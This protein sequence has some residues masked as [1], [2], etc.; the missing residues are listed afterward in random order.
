MDASDLASSSARAVRSWSVAQSIRHGHVSARLRHR[1]IALSTMSSAQKAALAAGYG[2]LFVLALLTAFHSNVA[3]T[4]MFRTA[5]GLYIPLSVLL[6]AVPIIVLVLSFATSAAMLANP[7]ARWGCVL[8]VVFAFYDLTLYATPY[9]LSEPDLAKRA[10]MAAMRRQAEL[11]LAAPALLLVLIAAFR[12]WLPRWVTPVGCLLV[13]SLAA[14]L[15]WQLDQLPG[16]E[17]AAW[18]VIDY[19]MLG[20]IYLIPALLVVGADIAEWAEIFGEVTAEGLPPMRLSREWA[21]AFVI[22]A[23]NLSIVG[24]WVAKSG[25]AWQMAGDPHASVASAGQFA[26]AFTILT[27]G[28]ATILALLLRFPSRVDHTGHFGYVTILAI[29]YLTLGTSM[30][31]SGYLTEDAPPPTQVFRLKEATFSIE[32]ARGWKPHTTLDEPDLAVVD[33]FAPEESFGIVKVIASRS[34]L[35][36]QI[37][38]V[39]DLIGSAADT[40]PSTPLQLTSIPPDDDGWR[41]FETTLTR[42]EH[43]HRSV[44]GIAMDPVTPELA[45]AIGLSEARGVEVTGVTLG[46]G[47]A[48][49]GIQTHDIVLAI[50]GQSIKNPSDL[51]RRMGATSPG[52][53]IDVL[54]MRNGQQQHVAVIAGELPDAEKPRYHVVVWAKHDA[55][56]AGMNNSRFDSDYILHSSCLADDQACAAAADAMLKSWSPKARQV[57]SPQGELLANW[58]WLVVVAIACCLIPWRR[59]RS[60]ARAVTLIAVTALAL[61]ACRMSGLIGAEQTADWGSGTQISRLLIELA[62][63]TAVVIGLALMAWLALSDSGRRHAVEVLRLITGLNLSVLFL[64]LAFEGL[65]RSSDSAEE[66]N[67]VKGLLVIGAL[68]WEITAS[69]SVTNIA[70]RYLPRGSRLLLFLAYVMLVAVTVFLFFPFR[71]RNSYIKAFNPEEIILRG[72]FLLGVPIIFTAFATRIA[73][74]LRPY[75]PADPI[76]KAE[77]SPSPSA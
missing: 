2:V 54:L 34:P 41:R 55:F 42:Y 29:A 21:L 27:M 4:A 57:P 33:F 22:I 65:L 31:L 60:D 23:T 9:P 36:Q 72:I 51:R 66:N 6:T 64:N 16:S 18:V 46:S 73:R 58:L 69:G 37:T 56:E 44:L 71:L 19:L 20:L 59:Q 12:G 8:L 53:P 62:T 48:N 45:R 43:M 38:S 47:A 74:L 25:G 10:A 50:D 63:S 40:F 70:T 17:I 68:T 75:S 61:F 67:V 15:I 49:A 11:E 77:I 5:V 76:A 32:P 13:F 28:L 52:S 30:F 35:D 39:N 26:L 7:V 1:I 14:V 3:S 24:L